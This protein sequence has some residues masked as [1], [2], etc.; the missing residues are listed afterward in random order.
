MG[1]NQQKIKEQIMNGIIKYC[2]KKLTTLKKD[3]CLNETK[4]NCSIVG[5][6]LVG[7]LKN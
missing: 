3:C 7:E 5:V 2:I 1:L 6:K 4:I